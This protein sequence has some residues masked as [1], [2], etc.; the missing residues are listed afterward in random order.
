[1]PNYDSKTTITR[2]DLL[3]YFSAT[4]GCYITCASPVLLSGCS[5]PRQTESAF[6]FPQGVASADPQADAIVLWTRVVGD[7]KETTLTTQVALDQDF[8]QIVSESQAVAAPDWDHTIR[9]LVTGLESNHYY[10]YRFITSDGGVSRTGRTKTAPKHDAIVPLNIAVF[11]CQDYEHGYFTAYRR[12]IVDNENA[13]NDKK[14][15][16]VMHVG[17]FFYETIRGPDTV[18]EPS[19]NGQVI[20]LTNRDG[21]KRRC[22]PFPSGGRVGGRKWLVPTELADYRWLYQTYLT[23]PDLQ[24]ARALFPFVQ[25]WDDH[26]LLNDCWQ[27]YY[28]EHSV[29]ELKVAANR[30]WFE[31]VP[32]A[33]SA[34]GRDIDDNQAK[35]FEPVETTNTPFDDFD[36]DYLSLEPNNLAAI[37][38]MTIYRSIQ[39][40]KMAELMMID[41]R[42]YRGPR[43]LPQELLS[44]GRH[45]Y[46]EAP[47]DPALIRL[48]SEGRTA[49]NGNPPETISY[50]GETM[51]NPRK[52]KP[53]GSMLGRAQKRWL[54]K[55]LLQSTAKWKLLGLNVGLMRHSFDDTFRASGFKNGLLWTDGWDGYPAE[56]TE[57]CTF[58]KNNQIV[59]VVSLTGDRHAHMAGVVYEDYDLVSS[60]AVLAEFAGGAASS[61]SRMIIQ[62]ELS[63]HDPDVSKLVTFDGHANGHEQAIMPSLNAWMLFGHATA[64]AVHDGESLE[65]AR[66]LA[67]GE[68]NSHLAYVDCDAHGYFVA[69]IT[70][71]A[72]D[73]SFVSVFEPV[74][75]PSTDEAPVRRRVSFSLPEWEPGEEPSM[76]NTGVAGEQPFGGLKDIT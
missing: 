53:R 29:A 58:I 11:S 16:F 21:S 7:S 73:A 75:L 61:V 13:P 57:L 2:R 12:L 6:T 54:E 30:A 18:P 66:S 48:L 55:R 41:G 64:K 23:D 56:R 33:L 45:P 3:K 67:D 51:P 49:N 25:V 47:V 37:G 36:D 42:S 34:G 70:D 8:S 60:D 32:A 44:V 31:Y 19:H 62:R 9:V 22:A 26:E 52:D 43:G 46:P 17:D 24:D 76:A 14:I 71:Q 38:S 1:M 74:A 68:V 15:D 4:V 63:A 69:S 28:K 72:I 40:G 35:D 50:L 65:T 20:E 27:S 5:T 59:N 10:Y 39:W